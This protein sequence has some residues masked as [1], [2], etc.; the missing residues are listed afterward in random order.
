MSE[1][2]ARLA[3]TAVAAE[4]AAKAVKKATQAVKKA[5]RDLRKQAPGTNEYGK[6]RKAYYVAK[7]RLAEARETTA[8]ADVD[9]ARAVEGVRTI[10]RFFKPV[11][12]KK[13][14][15]APVIEEEEED[16]GTRVALTW[17][18]AGE[19]HVGMQIIGEKQAA[20]TGFTVEELVKIGKAFDKAGVKCELVRLDQYTEEPAAVLVI[21]KLVKGEFLTQL[22]EELTSLDWDSKYYDRRRSKVLNKRA[23]TN[24]MFQHGVSAEPCYEEGRG[25]IV[26]IDSMPLLSEAERVL[27]EIPAK[28]LGDRWIPLVCEGNY[29]YDPKK[30][31][32]GF[33]GDTERT[34]VIC[35][36]VGGVDYPMRWQCFC[37]G[38]VVGHPVDVVLNSGD[39]Y[40]MSEKAVGNDWK[41]RTINTLRHAAGAKKYTG[42]AKKWLPSPDDV[43]KEPVR[44]IRKITTSSSNPSV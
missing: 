14:S 22:K 17:G 32:I 11:T 35:L 26:D 12:G 39:A 43:Q 33:H 5:L 15:P 7:K 28:V 37:R 10:R 16:D 27:H 1:K 24:L 6:C 3:A 29:Y 13:R 23:R 31:G 8:E 42:I 34:R 2:R 40:I 21:K 30:T 41:K 18:D 36:S 25:R 19:N 44:L 20:G 9:H 4:K 38:K